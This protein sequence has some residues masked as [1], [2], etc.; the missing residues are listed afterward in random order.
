M[1]FKEI[2]CVAL[3]AKLRRDGQAICQGRGKQIGNCGWR[4]KYA[5]IDSVGV[6]DLKKEIA[7]IERYRQDKGLRPVEA[8]EIG[9][10]VPPI[11][12]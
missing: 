3:L 6:W 7:V 10:A 8:V 11:S 2:L 1:S 4:V 12:L 5:E 9:E